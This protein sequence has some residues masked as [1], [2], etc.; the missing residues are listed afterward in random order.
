M[1]EFSSIKLDSTVRWSFAAPDHY[2]FHDAEGDDVLHLMVGGMKC[3]GCM[4]TIENSLAGFAELKE[5]RVNLS[6]QRLVLRW[7]RGAF[8]P[9]HAINAVVDKGFVLAPFDPQAQSE[10]QHNDNKKLLIA[11]G[12]AGFAAANVMMLSVAV[13]AGASSMGPETRVLFHWISALIALP[14]IVFS[15]RVFFNSALGALKAGRLNMDVPISLAVILAAGMSLYETYTGG[16]HAYFDAA[17][18][19]LFFLLIGRYLDQQARAKARSQGEHLLALQAMSATIERADGNLVTM[20]LHLVSKGMIVLVA[21]GEKIPVDGSVIGGESEVDNALITGESHPQHIA[22]GSQVYAGTINLLQPIRVEVTAVGEET[23]L[24]EIARLMEAAE[25][26]RGVFVRIADKVAGY[27]A[28]V[29]HG[30]GLLTFLGWW[31]VVGAAWQQALLYGIAVLIITCPC[32]LGLAVPAV[33][34]IATGRLMRAGILL[35]SADALERAKDIDLVVFDKTGTLTM[36]CLTPNFNVSDVDKTVMDMAS[37]MAANSMH[38]LA[39]AMRGVRPNAPVFNNVDEYAGKGLEMVFAGEIVRLGSAVWCGV[40]ENNQESGAEIWLKHGSNPAQRFGFKDTLR[41]D[42]I[43]V[44]STL[45]A[46]GIKTAL[47]SG[48]RQ[49]EVTS[50]AS[51]VGIIDYHSEMLPQEKVAWIEAQKREGRRVLMVGDGLNDAPA[52]TVANASLSPVSAADISLVTADMVFQTHSLKAVIEVLDVAKGSNRLVWQNF[53]MAFTYNIIAIPL[54]VAGI[55]TPLVA[56]IAMSTS[57]ILVI[58]NALRLK[59]NNREVK[60]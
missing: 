32:A 56:A 22:K 18:T 33:Q 7:Q 44:V 4:R 51:E 19:L 27:Y 28:P 6:T 17:I 37:G 45:H 21:V 2:S 15:G 47:L 24:G 36:G 30:L 31:L 9:A 23:L 8:D 50:I 60:A 20:P 34:V 13:W 29:V 25:Q 55:A 53:G 35:K 5:A 1:N 46:R 49:E 58:L 3:A 54:A 57:S 11:L 41:P 52:L 40:K 39:K 42:V 38:P 43:E 12:V 48:D 14:A 10:T 16:E 26:G 59:I